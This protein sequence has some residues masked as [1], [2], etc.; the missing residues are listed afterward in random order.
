MARRRRRP[1]DDDLIAL[2]GEYAVRRTYEPG[3][4]VPE[5]DE[6]P[7]GP[8][9]T[10]MSDAPPAAGNASGNS[11]SGAPGSGGVE[12]DAGTSRG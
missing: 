2:A 8:S 11:V 5:P 12:P 10:T 1:S 7:P 3:D 9:G 6:V 4:D